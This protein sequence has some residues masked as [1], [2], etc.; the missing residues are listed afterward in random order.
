MKDQS[1][2]F[3]NI[4]DKVYEDNYHLLRHMRKHYP[5]YRDDQLL[6]KLLC[7]STPSYSE[8][9]PHPRGNS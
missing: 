4:P 9:T 5:G 1:K 6:M 3:Q 8:K 7:V 2:L